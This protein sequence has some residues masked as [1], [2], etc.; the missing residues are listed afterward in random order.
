MGDVITFEKRFE[1]FHKANPRVYALLLELLRSFFT[2]TGRREVGFSLLWGAARW[3][4]ALE[5]NEDESG[6]KL[7]DHYAPFYARLI[8]GEHPSFG[9]VFELRASVAD[10]WAERNGYPTAPREQECAA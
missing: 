10:A 8:M 3:K 2:E 9:K 4:W 7:N 5:V 1:Q 6:F